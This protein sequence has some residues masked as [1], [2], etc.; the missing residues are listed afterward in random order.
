M[1]VIP[2]RCSLPPERGRPRSLSR[3]EGL[4]VLKPNQ[5]RSNAIYWQ[6]LLIEVLTTLGY[7]SPDPTVIMDRWIGGIDTANATIANE[8]PEPWE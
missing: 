3:Q 1:A 4:E 6:S 5:C 7:K 2:R 8:A